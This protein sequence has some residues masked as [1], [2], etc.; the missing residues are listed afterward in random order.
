M[1]RVRRPQDSAGQPKNRAVLSM[2]PQRQA[3]A[4]RAFRVDRA[5]VDAAVARVRA[6]RDE[7]GAECDCEACKHSEVEHPVCKGCGT[8]HAQRD[9]F[10][11]EHF[12]TGTC[13]R[14]GRVVQWRGGG[15]G[16]E[17]RLKP[18]KR[19]DG[20]WCGFRPSKSERL[21]ADT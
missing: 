7:H 18:H 11:L 13:E 16:G 20:T 21:Q 3:D 9:W 12:G 8:R 10:A 15:S 19:A 14:C 17:F 2:F 6:S 5:E 1:A 4:P